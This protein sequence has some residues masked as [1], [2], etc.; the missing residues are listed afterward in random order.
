MA[1]SQKGN[2]YP[3]EGREGRVNSHKEIMTQGFIF[4]ASPDFSREVMSLALKRISPP[5]T[6][7]ATKETQYRALHLMFIIFDNLGSKIILV[8]QSTGPVMEK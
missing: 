4:E 6:L 3:M 8:K 5:N 2:Q 7:Y 1:Y